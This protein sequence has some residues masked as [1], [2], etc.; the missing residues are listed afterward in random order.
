[1][2]KN[3]V[4]AIAWWNRPITWLFGIILIAVVGLGMLG[5]SGGPAPSKADTLAPVSA[6]APAPVKPATAPAT[7]S[8]GANGIT[9][10]GENNTVTVN[11][12]APAKTTEVTIIRPE[13][14]RTVYVEREVPVVVERIVE[15]PVVVERTTVLTVSPSFQAAV[16]C[17]E[18]ERQYKAKRAALRHAFNL[19]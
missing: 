4:V 5:K 9:I 12:P 1:M 17:G 14:Q 6:P 2:A 16:D 3:D 8:S 15:R 18:T 10:H 11:P 13:R 19:E 7:V